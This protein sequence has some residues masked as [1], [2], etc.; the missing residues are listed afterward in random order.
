MIYRLNY[1][2]QDS[3]DFLQHDDISELQQ[4]S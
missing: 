1:S 2:C 4:V 3:V